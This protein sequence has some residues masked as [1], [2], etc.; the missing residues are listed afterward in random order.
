MSWT[1]TPSQLR[2]TFPLAF[3]SGTNFFA[4]STGSE[5]PS[6]WPIC[7]TA[8]LIPTTSPWVFIRGPPLL[9]GLIGVS[10]CIKSSYGVAP[11]DL[12]LALTIPTVTVRSSPKGLPIAITQSPGFNSFELPSGITGRGSGES[13]FIRAKSA[14]LSIPISFPLKSPP[15]DNATWTESEF[16]TTWAL[17]RI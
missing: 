14:T 12:P 17:V 2:V 6:P 1:D 7:I 15:V 5:N 13:I 8:V 10:V 4:K 16:S 11:S 9:P 3:S